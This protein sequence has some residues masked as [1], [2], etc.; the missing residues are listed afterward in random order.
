MNRWK[1]AL[2]A[3]KNLG[4][5]GDENDL[6][7]VKAFIAEKNVEIPGFD[8]DAEHKKANTKTLIVDGDEEPSETEV[9]LTAAEIK[10][11]REASKAKAT[12]HKAG[13]HIA[14]AVEGTIENKSISSRGV[15]AS[16]KAYNV[17]AQSGK[18]KFGDADTAELF[19][20]WVRYTAAKQMPAIMHSDKYAD[21]K[22]RDVEILK[23]GSIGVESLG[24]ATVPN[25]LQPELIRLVEQYGKARQ[26]AGVFRMSSGEVTFPRRNSG[27][28]A[29][30]PGENTE[31]TASDMSLGT[32]KL[33]ARKIAALSVQSSEILADSAINIADLVAEELALAVAYT[34]DMCYF[35]GDGTSTYGGILG[36]SKSFEKIVTDAGGTWATNASNAAGIVVASG[37]AATEV[38]LQDLTEVVGRLPQ[39]AV[40]GAKWAMSS[41]AWAQISTRLSLSPATGGTAATTGVSYEL[42][43]GAMQPRLLGFPIEVVQ[44]MP[45]VDGNSQFLAYFGNFQKATKFGEVANSYSMAVSDQRY[46]EKDQIAF[47]LTNRFDINVHDLGNYSATASSRTPGPVIGLLSAAS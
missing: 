19:A 22:D 18:A 46:F 10:A 36:L 23:A 35:N 5:A 3:L 14:D 33:Y 37:N 11:F 6:N 20:A 29:Y 41:W 7:A 47:R 44:V 26:I 1:K 27:N 12:G 17:K 43:N 8:P 16:K 2:A 15:E 45:K 4:Y 31:I 40:P 21:Q 28:T 32:V 42:V 30:F 34:E 13:R 25:V 39:Y 24:G 9:A 38:T